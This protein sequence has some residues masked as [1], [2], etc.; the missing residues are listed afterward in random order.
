[1]PIEG[2]QP[3]GLLAAPVKDP[4]GMNVRHHR[5]FIRRPGY[6]PGRS[7][8]SRRSRTHAAL[9]NNRNGPA[10]ESQDWGRQQHPA[11][12]W[13]CIRFEKGVGNKPIQ[14]PDFIPRR[15]LPSSNFREQVL[16]F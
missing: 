1:M 15:R 5:R 7:V 14:T 2:V 16:T 10:M 13:K 12:I 9:D 11:N 4:S 8:H 3:V 6:A